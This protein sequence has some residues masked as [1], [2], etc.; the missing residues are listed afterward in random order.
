MRRHHLHL[1]TLLAL[2]TVLAPL[3]AGCDGKK[4]RDEGGKAAPTKTEAPPAPAKETKKEAKV[5][6]E[7]KAPPSAAK[8]RRFRKGQPVPPGLSPEE[9]AEYNR[10]Q[11]DP[12]ADGFTLEEAFEGAPELADK[13]KGKL[14][15]EF[16]TSMGSFDCELFEDEAPLTVANFVGLAR[17]VRPFYDKKKDAW[18]ERPFYDGLIFHRVIRNFMIQ[19]GDPLGSGTGGPGYHIVDEIS[20]KLKHS[21]PGI[22]SM[23]N[24]G[25][26]TGSSQ[27]FITVRATPHLDGKHTVFG[28]C[29]PKVPVEIS[30]VKTDKRFDRPFDPPKIEKIR[31]VRKKKLGK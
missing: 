1:A 2:S 30:K 18:V 23:A 21:G 29:Q 4:R 14:V 19:T 26:N 6:G 27:F 10:A 7:A 9:L 17:G 13:S 24:R 28:R 5:A 12:E 8:R 3:S 11:G 15:A 16:T 20:P 22:L 31:I 25:P